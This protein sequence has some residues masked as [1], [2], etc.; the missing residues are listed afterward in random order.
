MLPLRPSRSTALRWLALALLCAAAPAGAHGQINRPPAPTAPTPTTPPRARPPTDVGAIM[1]EAAEQALVSVPDLSGRTVSEARRLLA[2]MGLGMGRVSEGPAGSGAPGTIMQQ[3][4]RAGSSVARLSDVRVWLVPAREASAPQGSVLSRPPVQTA[5]EPQAARVRVPL[6]VGRSVEDARGM[7]AQVTLEV[8]SVGE[9]AADGTPGTIV[10][11]SPRAGSTVAPKS[12]VQLWIVPERQVAQ[13]PQEPAVTTPAPARLVRVPS[14]VGRTVEDAQRVIAAAGLAPG[15]LA[16]AGGAGAP[17]TVS[18]Q[19]P[20]AGASVAANSP[21]RLWLV[22]PGSVGQVATRPDPAPP[23]APRPQPPAQRPPPPAAQ[24]PAAQPPAPQT[25][26]PAT[27]SAPLATTDAGTTP[28]VTTPPVTAPADSAG[29]PDVRRMRLDQARGALTAAGFAAAFDVALAD[30]AAWTVSAQQPGPGA[31]LASG[32]VVALLLDP[33]ASASAPLAGTTATPQPPLGNGLQ[34][35]PGAS[36]VQAPL[37]ERKTLWIA[38]A[39][40]LLIAAA[41]AAAKRM[42]GGSRT[43]PFTTVSARLRMDAPAR[44]AVEG[45]PFGPGRL[46]FRMNPGRT[47]AHVSAA[48]PLFVRKEVSGD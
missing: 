27:P 4:P 44:V 38:L 32:G 41:A 21:V 18:R 43:L 19:Q 48:G 23:P 26:A 11:Q 29:V 25:P 3:Q 28:P 45:A 12:G 20:A 2:S 14:L 34:A 24:P 37:W 1:A 17:G 35:S 10:R 30:S 6:L 46:R 42:R 9:I 13:Q 8:A 47:V 5:Q 39:A 7:L 33:P 15:P 16:E 36:K 31:R 22:P 40:L